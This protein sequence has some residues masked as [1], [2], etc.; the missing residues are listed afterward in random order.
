MKK[1]SKLNF[2]LEQEQIEDI[3]DFKRALQILYPTVVDT[4]LQSKDFIERY[5]LII[6]KKSNY[7]KDPDENVLE[8]EEQDG[9]KL[10]KKR[11]DEDMS[12]FLTNG[13]DRL[14]KVDLSLEYLEQHREKTGI[15]GSWHSFFNLFKQ[16]LDSK[17]VSLKSVDKQVIKRLDTNTFNQ[18][19]YKKNQF[20]LNTETE[21]LKDCL[22]LQIH[23]PLMIG[24][25]IT[26]TFDMTDYEIKG[27]ERHEIIK[28]L[29]LNLADIYQEEKKRN[30]DKVN[31]EKDKKVNAISD[32]FNNLHVND[33]A[34]KRDQLVSYIPDSQANKKRKPKGT[35]VNPNLKKRKVQGAKF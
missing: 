27:R 28:D 33:S 26:G 7:N 16:A 32:E 14:F 19:K 8:D 13:F 29:L 24:A 1:G 20:H 10:N 34:S 30:K 25:R 17:S 31:I 12:L 35:L 4:I 9:K 6:D 23:Y 3:G 15:E 5:L 22:I 18:N 21:V 2:S 11:I